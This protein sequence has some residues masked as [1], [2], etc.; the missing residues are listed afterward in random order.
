MISALTFTLTLQKLAPRSAPPG[1]QSWGRTVGKPT[2]AEGTQPGNFKGP[3]LP[4]AHLSAGPS[5]DSKRGGGLKLGPPL[6]FLASH[7]VPA[8]STKRSD[9]GLGGTG[10][11]PGIQARLPAL[12]Q[13]CSLHGKLAEGRQETS[14]AAVCSPAAAG[15][16]PA[17]PCSVPAA[18]GPSSLRVPKAPELPVP[19]KGNERGGWSLRRG[20]VCR[21][22]PRHP[23]LPNSA[24]GP[25]GPNSRH[26]PPRVLGEEAPLLL[27]LPLRGPGTTPM[28]QTPHLPPAPGESRGLRQEGWLG[29][30]RPLLLQALSLLS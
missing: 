4:A 8:Q 23:V 21:E 24:P 17:L 16:V 6:L 15:G 14:G 29:A 1:L 5:L 12:L 13:A 26:H 3:L 25:E 19:A 20:R 7:S 11:L 30:H 28:K 18:P 27:S 10:A 2:R 22:P 9:Q